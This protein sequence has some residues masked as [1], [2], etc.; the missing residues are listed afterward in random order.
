MIYHT[1]CVKGLKCRNK[2]VNPL[3]RLTALTLTAEN[4][5]LLVFPTLKNTKITMLTFACT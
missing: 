2:S 4:A 1:L 3:M 5:D